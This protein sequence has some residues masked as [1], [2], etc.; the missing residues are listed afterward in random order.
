MTT[1]TEPQTHN[2]N[3]D[4]PSF[5]A[6]L[7]ESPELSAAFD[8]F[9]E[10]RA[11]FEPTF[12]HRSAATHVAVSPANPYEYDAPTTEVFE[13]PSEDDLSERDFFNPEEYLLAELFANATVASEVHVPTPVLDALAVA[14]SE[15]FALADQTQVPSSSL[16]DVVTASPFVNPRPMAFPLEFKVPDGYDVNEL[17]ELSEVQPLDLLGQTDSATSVSPVVRIAPE[18][19]QFTSQP[20]PEPEPEPRLKVEIPVLVVPTLL[21]PDTITDSEDK[22]RG[23]KD[24]SV[25][26]LLEPVQVTETAYP[27]I[28]LSTD[29]DVLD[30]ATVAMDSKQSRF[31]R[32]SRVPKVRVEKSSEAEPVVEDGAVVKVARKP[33]IRTAKAGKKSKV[34]PT[35]GETKEEETASPMSKARRNKRL[36]FATSAVGFT[37]VFVLVGGFVSAKVLGFEPSAVNTSRLAPALHDT[38]LV[39]SKVAP[40][41]TFNKG[42]LVVLR[43]SDNT[44]GYGIF[45]ASVNDGTIQM[46]NNVD[47]KPVNIAVKSLAHPAVTLPSVGTE[48]T[49]ALNTSIPGVLTG[50]AFAGAIGSVML[51][52]KV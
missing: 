18:P 39:M 34:T 46:Y 11:R 28:R 3:F 5:L 33:K 48:V 52:R 42:D 17:P 8:R 4:D 15:G 47:L 2:L 10:T 24:R 43:H 30:E 16:T 38:D 14:E 1:N 37:V 21:P 22:P 23:R 31:A 50:I 20:E 12:T 6:A 26:A 36:L 40:A 32:K 7:A 9:N 45:Y 44:L 27:D 19:P 41:S 49:Y 35:D 29:V 51:R 25:A 13:P